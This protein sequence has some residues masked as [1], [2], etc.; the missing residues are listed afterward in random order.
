MDDGSASSKGRTLYIHTKGFTFA[1][2]Y[3][4]AAMLHYNFGLV[5]NVQS[6]KDKPVIYIPSASIPLLRSIVM[7]HMHPSML[8]KLP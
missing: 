6:H 4:L 5:V 2:V 3:L 1:D 8:Y 7:P